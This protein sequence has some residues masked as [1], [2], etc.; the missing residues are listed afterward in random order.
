[1]V[2]MD[3]EYSPKEIENWVT[4][5]QK[6]KWAFKQLENWPNHFGIWAIVTL[7]LGKDNQENQP[8]PFGKRTISVWKNPFGQ[9]P[10][11]TWNIGKIIFQ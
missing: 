9:Q 7:I 3:Q 6:W 10:N 2:K 8:N 11:S 4:Q 5:R 1:M